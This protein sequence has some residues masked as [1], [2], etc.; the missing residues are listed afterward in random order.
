MRRFPAFLFPWS[1]TESEPSDYQACAEAPVPTVAAHHA[2]TRSSAVTRLVYPLRIHDAGYH[3]H[4][5]QQ[6]YARGHATI[7][8]DIHIVGEGYLQLDRTVGLVEESKA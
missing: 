1:R 7:Q 5:G 6:Y 4:K 2:L 8:E 3:I